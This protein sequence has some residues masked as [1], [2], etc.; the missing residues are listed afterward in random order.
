[1]KINLVGIS[2]LLKEGR[3]D[4]RNGLPSRT[5]PGELLLQF[6]PWGDWAEGRGV[7]SQLKGRESPAQM[8]EIHMESQP[9]F[10]RAART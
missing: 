7:G 3:M 2:W 10:K 4:F 5:V 1:M 9:I 6:C 8:A